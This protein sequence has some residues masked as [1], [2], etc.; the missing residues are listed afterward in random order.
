[1]RGARRLLTYRSWRPPCDAIRGRGSVSANRDNRQSLG[2]KHSPLRLLRG[3]AQYLRSR[4]HLRSLPSRQDPAAC[5][6]LWTDRVLYATHACHTSSIALVR[7]CNLRHLALPQIPPLAALILSRWPGAETTH[8]S[9]NCPNSH[10]PRLPLDFSTAEN[11]ANRYDPIEAS[12][13]ITLH[14][15]E[16]PQPWRL[17]HNT[18]IDFP[19]TRYLVVG[20]YSLELRV[21]GN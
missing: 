12:P 21:E 6:L 11:L 16:I 8:T 1:M 18:G 9:D 10:L 13:C 17:I 5:R 15:R 2:Q 3:E 7:P 19:D 14:I 20:K 4:G